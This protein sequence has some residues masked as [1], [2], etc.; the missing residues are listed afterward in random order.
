MST[1]HNYL[2]LMGR[3]LIVKTLGIPLFSIPATL[4][5]VPPHIIQCVN[6]ILYHYVWNGKTDKIKRKIFIQEFAN[7]GLKMIDFKNYVKAS[8][9]KFIQR[10]L[11]SNNPSK[12]NLFKYFC[13]VQ[14]VNVYLRSNFKLE[15]IKGE[16]PTYYK[17]C[18]MAWKEIRANSDKHTN[19]I[20]YNQDILI[21]NKTVFNSHLFTAGVWTI[22]DLFED[23]K[24]IAFRVWEKRGVP[25]SEFLTWIGLVNTSKGHVI[26]NYIDVEVLNIGAVEINNSFKTIDVLSFKEIR[27]KYDSI[28]LKSL[29]GEDFK[30]KLKFGCLY[31]NIRDDEWRKTYI[32]VT[33]Q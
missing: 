10:F 1:R 24:P 7:G 30:A 19:F 6:E 18:L 5:H 11:A 32:C 2:S 26:N 12:F 13:G 29:K 9:C 15:E 3:I 23:N 25:K 33:E 20:W 4:L 28:L 8:K 27:Q 31:G 17:D 14:N 22:Y 16:M 21:N